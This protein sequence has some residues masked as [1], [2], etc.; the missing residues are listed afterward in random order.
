LAHLLLVFT[1]VVLCCAPLSA[2]Q[3]NVFVET[4]GAWQSRNDARIPPQS[5][6]T[7]P[8]DLNSPQPQPH[9]RA[10]FLM[11]LSGR[12]QLRGVF[13]PFR[14]RGVQTLGQDTEFVDDTFSEG[15]SVNTFYQ[16]NSYRLTYLYEWISN[17]SHQLSVGLT[18][19]VRD[20]KIRLSRM[21][22]AQ[23]FTDLG[24]VPLIYLSY[25]RKL[26][27]NWS[28]FTDLDGAAAPQG[29]AFDFS[30][31]IRRIIDEGTQLG[32]GYRT[33]EGG[34]DNDKVFTF[35][36]FHYGVIEWVATF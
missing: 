17:D 5:D 20:A 25:Q 33:L 12:H 32:I 2:A 7:I 36:W 6:A 35:S 24:F 11:E 23:E 21:S 30:L 9:F 31:K 27:E 15:Q 18:V 34:A 29:R 19:K 16:F 10:E 1:L 4:G 26:S 13:A 14:A 3:P 22:Q 28:L 8:L